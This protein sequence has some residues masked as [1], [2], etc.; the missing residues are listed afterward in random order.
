ML[1]TRNSSL[2]AASRLTV[3]RQERV[4]QHFRF[5][6][7]ETVERILSD[8]HSEEFYALN[9]IFSLV[10]FFWIKPKES[11]T[12][13]GGGPEGDTRCAASG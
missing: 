7:G 11:N 2:L 3:V 8:E 5:A 12:T 10:T 6:L 1:L 9:L 4:S 13:R